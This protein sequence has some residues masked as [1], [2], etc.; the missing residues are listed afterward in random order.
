MRAQLALSQILGD[1]I[2]KT[3]FL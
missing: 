2:L 1:Y 3:P